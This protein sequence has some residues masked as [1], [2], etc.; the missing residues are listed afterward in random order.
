[1]A[2]VGNQPE[3][4]K[5]N[6]NLSYVESVSTLPPDS[7]RGCMILEFIDLVRKFDFVRVILSKF[8]CR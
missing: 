6:I 3:T 5:T 8:R 4:E 1:M 2:L 7:E